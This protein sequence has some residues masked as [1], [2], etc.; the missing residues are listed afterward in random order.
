MRILYIPILIIALASCSKAATENSAIDCSGP[1]KTYSLDVSNVLRTSCNDD[2]GCH[3]S[4]SKNGP[5]ELLNFQQVFNARTAIR[6]AIRSGQMPLNGKLTTEQ[7]NAILCW[8][9][10]GSPNN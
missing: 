1:A 8:I 9:N 5:G 7:K 10:N 6:S 4:G 3:G 2:S